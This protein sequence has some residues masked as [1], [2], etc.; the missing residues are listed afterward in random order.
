MQSWPRSDAVD[1]AGLATMCVL[2]WDVRIRCSHEMHYHCGDD[3]ES[4]VISVDCTHP[5][6]VRSNFKKVDGGKEYGPIAG[7]GYIT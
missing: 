7:F 5:I 6:Y 1:G 3:R 4:F 2:R